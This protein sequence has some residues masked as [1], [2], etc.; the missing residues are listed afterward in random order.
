MAQESDGLYRQLV[1]AT[2]AK[3]AKWKAN[4]ATQAA[5]NESG[6]AASGAGEAPRYAAIK[7]F[8][9]NTIIREQLRYVRW[10]KLGM[11]CALIYPRSLFM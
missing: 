1:I 3:R 10:V 2:A 4:P 5:E 7:V 6:R 8:I 11:P 9:R